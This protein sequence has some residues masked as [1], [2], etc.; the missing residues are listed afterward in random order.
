MMNP[1]SRRLVVGLDVILVC[2]L[3]EVNFTSHNKHAGSRQ[4]IIYLVH[5]LHYKN[6]NVYQL[7]SHKNF[8]S[9]INKNI[10]FPNFAIK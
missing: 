10:N 8:S 9:N 2:K 4:Q 5:I 3:S 7:K 1:H 6:I